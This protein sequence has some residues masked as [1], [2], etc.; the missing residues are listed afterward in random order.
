M[1]HKALRQQLSTLQLP[2]FYVV[3]IHLADNDLDSEGV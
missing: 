1:Y 3:A 2:I